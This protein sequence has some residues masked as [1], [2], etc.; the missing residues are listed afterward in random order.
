VAAR[1]LGQVEA[2]LIVRRAL[3]EAS[4]ASDGVLSRERSD[5]Y[6]FGYGTLGLHSNIVDYCCSRDD[7]IHFTKQKTLGFQMLLR[8]QVS[9]FRWQGRKKESLRLNTET[10]NLDSRKRR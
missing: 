8:C 10:S 3:A 9:G 1:R 5:F 4:T 6:R 2:Y 7:L